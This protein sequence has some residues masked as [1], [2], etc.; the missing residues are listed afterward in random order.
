[1]PSPESAIA[2]A[3][4]DALALGR[5]L[6]A[7]FRSDDLARAIADRGNEVVVFAHD[8]RAARAHAAFDVRF[9]PWLA[10]DAGPFDSVVLLL[11]RETERFRM[12]LA[13]ARSVMAE[14]AHLAVAGHNDGGIKS[15]GRHIAELVGEPDVLDYRFHC[16]VVEAKASVASRFDPATWRAE[17]TVAV[18]DWHTQVV[19]YPGV[20]AHG[21]LDVGTEALLG[22]AKVSKSA[23]AL[24]MAC[25][26]GVIGAWL[27][28]QGC[29]VDACDADAVAVRAASETLAGTEARVF[30]SDLFS[31]VGEPYDVIL[32]NPPFHAGIHT[33]A[34]VTERL[35]EGAPQHLAR[36][37]ELW[38]VGNRFLDYGSLLEGAFGKIRVVT[39]NTRYRVW[40]ARR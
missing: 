32:T 38:L 23:R 6:L 12:Y 22:T 33:T 9:G 13:M 25:G 21:R 2:V 24:D 30:A 16:R 18:G 40:H 17:H 7:G 36:G 10:E 31:D 20:F 35:I 39:E 11:P 4:A 28:S 1:M 34:A 14:G 29:V 37:G 3:N 8:I 26:N 5:V 19:S 15:S 27:L